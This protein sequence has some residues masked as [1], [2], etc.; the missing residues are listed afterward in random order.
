MSNCN[1]T[2]C[3]SG[4]SRLCW[5]F[6]II[7]VT[8]SCTWWILCI[9]CR[10]RLIRT[11]NLLLCR[12]GFHILIVSSISTPRSLRLIGCW[13]LSIIVGSGTDRSAICRFVSATYWLWIMTCMTIWQ[14]IWWIIRGTTI[15]L[16]CIHSDCIYRIILGVG[17][18][19]LSPIMNIILY[20]NIIFYSKIC[21]I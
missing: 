21:S 12:A 10:F 20:T 18:Y 19:F 11:S 4:S 7:F 9:I 14:R 6:P 8:T 3:V 5:L 13:T 15:F 1:S 2:S 16:F 17:Y